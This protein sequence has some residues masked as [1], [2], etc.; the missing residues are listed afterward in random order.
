MTGS[1]SQR[2]PRSDGARSAGRLSSGSLAD[3]ANER[4]RDPDE[5]SG[6]LAKTIRWLGILLPMVLSYPLLPIDGFAAW[7]RPRVIAAAAL[8]LVLAAVLLVRR[9]WRGAAA[10]TAVYVIVDAWWTL[11]AF[12]VLR[13]D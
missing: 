12:R 9:D 4:S 1:L 11:I 7:L 6:G 10:I 3:G 2:R 8:W 13:P 5:R